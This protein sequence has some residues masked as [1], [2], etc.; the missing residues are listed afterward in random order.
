MEF[1]VLMSIL[2]DQSDKALLSNM[3]SN[4]MEEPF[5]IKQLMEI[6][7]DNGNYIIHIEYE[8][9][10]SL[11]RLAKEY[12][13][14]CW[15]VYLDSIIGGTKIEKLLE[16]S[17]R[18]IYYT[19]APNGLRIATESEVKNGVEELE[20][21]FIPALDDE[22]QEYMNLLVWT[23]TGQLRYYKKAGLTYTYTDGK[24]DDTMY[25]LI[26]R[27]GQ[28]LRG[29]IDW[30]LVGGNYERAIAALKLSKKNFKY[31]YPNFAADEI[32]VEMSP[33]QIQYLCK[34]SIQGS[35]GSDNQAE[36]KRILFKN[37]KHDYK[38]LPHDIAVMRA[39]YREVQSGITVNKRGLSDE[40]TELIDL[41]LSGRD[42]GILK[43]EHFVFKIIHTVQSTG[44]CSA[45]QLAV[46]ESAKSE[47]EKHVIKSV[48][49]EKKAIVNADE[50]NMMEELY[51][52]SEALGSGILE[53]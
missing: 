23:F 25:Q 42:K 15:G 3:S 14:A 12:F 28:K 31:T 19:N 37:E 16:Y 21:K 29:L 24:L 41:V 13:N 53:V 10:L 47:I 5:L 33:K 18:V 49:D 2:T 8:K 4:M 38:V 51:S 48:K 26:H 35:G 7:S 11:F 20:A 1:S 44:R 46:I 40:L 36:A 45:K 22:V 30:I 39:A 17:E 43:R 27:A 50:I 32:Q 52:M 9:A 6:L 34:I